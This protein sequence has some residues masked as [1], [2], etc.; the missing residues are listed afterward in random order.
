MDDRARFWLKQ[1]Q[2]MQTARGLKGTMEIIQPEF[3]DREDPARLNRIYKAIQKFN[4]NTTW[5]ATGLLG[6]VVFAALMIALQDLQSKSED[7]ASQSSVDLSP[8]PSGVAT[9]EAT[10]IAIS[11]AEIVSE[12]PAK[13]GPGSTPVINQ[14]AVKPDLTSQSQVSGASAVS[15][16]EKNQKG[17]LR[18]SAHSRYVGAKARLIALWHQHLRHQ[19]SLGWT[20]SNDWRKKKISY[21][22]A[23]NH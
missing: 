10:P 13:L 20:L 2:A 8:G 18:S 21:T 12:Q 6:S 9:T 22:A 23:T 17:R 16:N 19:K 14:P 11:N 7:L 1:N 15:I 4:R 3:N 5:V